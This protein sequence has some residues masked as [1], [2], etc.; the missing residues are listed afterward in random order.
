MS[1]CLTVCLC[2]YACDVRKKNEYKTYRENTHATQ[3]VS[4]S[5]SADYSP[6]CV[7]AVDQS[8]QPTI[9]RHIWMLF[10]ST[11]S[12][13][14]RFFFFLY[15]SFC[16]TSSGKSCPKQAAQQTK[17][18]CSSSLPLTISSVSLAY[19]KECCLCL[20]ARLFFVFFNVCILLRVLLQY[21]LLFQTSS[22]QRNSPF[23]L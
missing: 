2:M 16:W 3:L 7:L 21:F 15:Y 22:R 9:V 20:I 6:V 13:V 23:R 8:D 19:S 14:C 10:S 1:V 17:G 12:N 5:L 11:A 4:P 18:K